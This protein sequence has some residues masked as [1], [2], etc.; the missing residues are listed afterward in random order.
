VSRRS[1]AGVCGHCGQ[2]GPLNKRATAEHPD[3]CK[4]CYARHQPKRPCGICG[5]TRQVRIRARDGQPDICGGCAPKRHAPCGLC[6][7]VGVIAVKATD[8]SPAIGRCC[9][10]PAIATCSCC[11]RERPC[12]HA[13]GPD[14]VCL[15]CRRGRRVATCVDCGQQR[16]AQRR[17]SGGVV[18]APCDRRR[19]NT[20]GICAGC[21]ANAPL[22]RELCDACRLR[23]RV[24]QLAAGGDRHARA[25]LAPYLAALAAAPNPTSTLRWLQ[26]PTLALLQDLLA[27]RIAV[28]HQA[29]DVAQGDAHTGRAVGYVRAALIDAGVLEPRDEHSAAFGHWQHGA[30][31]AIAPGPDRGRVRAY[32]TWHVAHHLA[33]TSAR[34]RATPATQKHARSLV[35]E[36]IKLVLWLH[37]QQFEL[38]DLRQ[39]LIDGWIADGASTRRRV[40][41]FLQWLARAGVTVDLHVTWKH[42]RS[43]SCP[44]G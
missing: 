32:A 24:A 1:Q 31:D 8:S 33:Q 29:L 37:E 18:C 41:I 16:P 2:A 20:R 7:R 40:R 42:A 11:A 3:L 35:S 15:S 6:R 34:C 39:D 25:V 14:P 26:R 27:G 23:E 4:R 30:L 9:W 17:V 19:G 13:T 5:K 43:R 36:A 12:Y 10:R 28:T 22:R 44:A 38:R 21:G